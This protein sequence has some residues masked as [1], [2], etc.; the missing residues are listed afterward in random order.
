MTYGLR[1]IA[2]VA[3]L[4][5]PPTK[6]DARKLQQLHSSLFGSS[7]CS[8]RDFRLTSAGAQLSNSLGGA[9]GQPVSCSTLLGDRIQIREEQT[10]ISRDDF[11]LRVQTMARSAL[12]ELPIQAFLAQQ[13][14]VR[15]VIG[16]P[17]AGENDDARRFI[18]RSMLGFDEGI[19]GAFGREPSLGGV[20]LAFP[21]DGAGGGIYNVRVE[22][23]TMDNR[24]LFLENVG[25][26]AS[27]VNLQGLEV[28]DQ[29][30]EA[31][32]QFLQDQLVGFVSQFSSD[33]VP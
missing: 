19:I 30:F 18:L 23:F 33:D 32:Y 6:H 14:A 15:S 3:E 10:G 8:Y 12:S 17:G 4:I 9:P 29:R 16:M 13:Y 31:T 1:S 25:T 22:S 20:R 24:S 21:P 5:H 26:F 2:F 27:P 7:E 11:Q 28:L